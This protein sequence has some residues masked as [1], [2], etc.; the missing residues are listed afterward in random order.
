MLNLE[1]KINQVKSFTSNLVAKD[2]M[3]DVQGILGRDITR[4]D[5]AFD[6]ICNGGKHK[7]DSPIAV[8]NGSISTS[9]FELESGATDERKDE[10]DENAGDGEN[11]TAGDYAKR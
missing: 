9:E 10:K 4:I 3:L 1:K 7:I 5:D 6:E 2:E 8:R 11:S